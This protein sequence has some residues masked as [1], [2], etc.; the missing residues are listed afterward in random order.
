MII[1]SNGPKGP[2]ETSG[3]WTSTHSNIGAIILGAA[4]LCWKVFGK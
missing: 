2:F 1:D 3:P 4:G